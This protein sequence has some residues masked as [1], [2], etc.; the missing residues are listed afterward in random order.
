MTSVL[1]YLIYIVQKNK[2]WPSRTVV[3]FRYIN[4]CMCYF[5]SRPK[6]KLLYS[7]PGV[8]AI[9]LPEMIYV[10]FII[11]IQSL[12]CISVANMI[13]IYTF[14]NN[15]WTGVNTNIIQWLKT[16][17]FKYTN[18]PVH[19]ISDGFISHMSWK[20]WGKSKSK[21]LFSCV[22]NCEKKILENLIIWRLLQS[23]KL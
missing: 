9:L 12:I 16:K 4:S 20:P 18:K 23:N 22:I 17:C 10:I 21:R 8:E 1:E 19:K 6:K 15:L 3:F 2:L 7:N 11:W 13:T 14:E 5:S